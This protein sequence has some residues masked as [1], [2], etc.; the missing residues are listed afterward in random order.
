MC[1][2]GLDAKVAVKVVD[3]LEPVPIQPQA[4]QVDKG[5]KPTQ[6]FNPLVG[7]EEFF[8]FCMQAGSKRQPKASDFPIHS[9][10]A[11]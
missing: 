11:C 10:S 4:L 8:A 7:Q 1:I 6:L 5:F 9:G 3:F 2:Q